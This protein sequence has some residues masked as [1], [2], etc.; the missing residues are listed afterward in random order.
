[1]ILKSYFIKR[2]HLVG[3]AKLSWLF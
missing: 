3:K 2:V 1:M